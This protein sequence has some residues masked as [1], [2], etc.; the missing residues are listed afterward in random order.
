MSKF[1]EIHE[2]RNSSSI[3][4]DNMSEIYSISD[5]SSILPMWIAD[6]DFP[7]PPALAD[8]I[9]ERLKHPIFGYTFPNDEVKKA[10]TDWYEVRHQWT[11]D[12]STIL[13]QQ[14]V[15]PAIATIIET[16]TEVGDKIGMS[17]PAYPPF[18]NVP[19]AQQR[20]IVTADLT[21]K[22]GSYAFDFNVLEELFQ[23]GIK[24]YIL[25]NPHNP[26]GVVW[27]HD[28]L[29]K[30]IQLCIQYDVYLL[31]DEIHADILI[32]KNYTPALT[33]KGAEQAKIL[34]CI[35]PT[36]TF[37]IAGVHA[38]MIVAPN[39]EL[40]TALNLSAQA[41]GLLSL[42][43]FACTA[44]KAVYTE[45]AQW[46]D[47]LLSYLKVNM[48]Y[49]S[50]ELNAIDGIRVVI[51]EATYLMWI[52]Y[53]GTGLSE[54]DMMQLLLSKGQLALDPGTKYGEAGRGF[55]RINV[56]CPLDTLKEGIARFKHALQS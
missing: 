16:F 26:A 27:S 8:A 7:A 42:N 41:H 45:G 54:Q 28:D 44:V 30:L 5:T 50:D 14:G 15:V 11:I 46:L 40:F 36:K 25:C 53:R 24:L 33:V 19:I 51:P 43:I 21:E 32:T 55:L 31:S 13:F 49:V 20:E 56:A 38:A 22:D 37:N 10:I 4:W 12:P 18:F 34:A 2:R 29:E 9:N 47:E 17:T 3:K 6:M 23:S 39:E 35:A 1:S 48:Q 52:D